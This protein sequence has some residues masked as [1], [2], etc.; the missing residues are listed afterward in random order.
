MAKKRGIS[1]R[2][3]A[4]ALAMDEANLRKILKPYGQPDDPD[5]HQG[6]ARAPGKDSRTH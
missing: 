5:A 1:N 2:K 3:L 4:K 6:R